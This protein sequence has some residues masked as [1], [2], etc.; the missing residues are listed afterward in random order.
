MNRGQNP[1]K[2]ERFERPLIIV[3]APRSGST[4]LFETLQQS[5]DL[6]SIGRESHAVF[7]QIPHLNPT[8]GICHSNLL[9]KKD[10]SAEICAHIKNNFWQLCIDRNKQSLGLYKEK[11]SIRFLEKTPKNSLRIDF[12][13][14]IFNDAYYIYLVRDV[15]QNLSSMIEA[16]RSGNFITY[17]ALSNWQGPWSLM[18]PPEYPRLKN[19]AL[20]IIV[21]YQWYMANNSIL[22]D[23]STLESKQ[24]IFL[25]YEALIHNTKDEILKLCRAA[26][27]EF[28]S[29]LST[30]CEDLPLSKT[31]QTAPRKDKWKKNQDMIESVLPLLESTLVRIDQF[32]KGIHSEPLGAQQFFE[33]VPDKLLKGKKNNA[34]AV[35]QNK[36]MKRNAICYCG[37]GKRF[38][39]C[40]GA[41]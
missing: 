37:S 39:H 38:K 3:A 17:P 24:S 4:L 8:K 11:Q 20:E 35:I 5:P 40:H 16:W 41:N 9:T 22:N 7:E 18:L 19:M 1:L 34:S 29:H 6:W 23:L 27:V 28:D 31:T 30:Y 21:A 36:Q 13:K 2:R 15:R 32:Q 25:D 12:L 33:S 14:Q 10:A 26:D